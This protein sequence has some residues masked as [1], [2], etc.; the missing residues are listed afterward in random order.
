MQAL[1][2]WL[3]KPNRPLESLLLRLGT[4]PVPCYN[5]A[6]RQ[7]RLIPPQNHK[8]VPS[9]TRLRYRWPMQQISH[10]NTAS[11]FLAIST[12]S[13]LGNY[14][15]FMVAIL[16]VLAVMPRWIVLA[17]GSCGALEVLENCTSYVRCVLLCDFHIDNILQ[18]APKN[19]QAIALCSDPTSVCD[20]AYGLSIGRGSFNWTAGAWTNVRQT[21]ALNTPGER[22]GGFSLDVN[23][24]RVIDR[25]DVFYRDV[26][27]LPPPGLDKPKP[28]PVPVSPK[29]SQVPSKTLKPNPITMGKPVPIATKIPIHTT[30]KA[31]T[32]GGILGPLLGGVLRR[33]VPPLLPKATP[34]PQ[35]P[36]TDAAAAAL[37]AAGAVQTPFAIL[38]GPES[39][40]GV[41]D[42]TSTV[43]LTATA[44]AT[45]TVTAMVTSTAYP[46]LMPIAMQSSLH[47]G[48][49]VP[50][51]GIFFRCVDIINRLFILALLLS[52]SLA[53]SLEDINGNTP[54]R[55]ISIL[56]SR[57]LD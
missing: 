42:V 2:E 27:K 37:I 57:T 4:I 46:S 25:R 35:G 18:Y 23:G 11:F 49:P 38:F 6:I 53:L 54:L 8:E 33:D 43:T 10:L 20:A 41:V 5:C 55:R 45:R 50:F 56:G 17:L 13:S 26:V 3:L 12:G 51:V 30:K 24:K 14:L 28:K 52:G 15:V 44:T 34:F 32:L 16:G 19:K 48:K 36:V 9:S 40:L 22:D 7:T 21:V 1:Q 31:P 39:V 29:Y 47:A